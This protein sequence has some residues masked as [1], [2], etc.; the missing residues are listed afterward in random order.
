MRDAEVT[1]E[2]RTVSRVTF[3]AAAQTLRVGDR[4]DVPARAH[5]RDGSGYVLV[6]G[7]AG[8][9]V[10][11]AIRGPDARISNDGRTERLGTAFFDRVGKDP[12]LATL[13]VMVLFLVLQPAGS[14]V[15]DRMK[16]AVERYL[17][18]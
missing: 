4:I 6:D 14:V 5:R 18:R 15:A 3:Q 8:M 7:E 17:S 1:L 10:S 11:F 13:W 16:Q 9:S 2:D 12:V